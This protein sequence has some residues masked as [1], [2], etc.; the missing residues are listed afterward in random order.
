[1]NAHNEPDIAALTDEVM[2]AGVDVIRAYQ[3]LDEFG[4]SVLAARRAEVRWFELMRAWMDAQG[5][6]Q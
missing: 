1:M 3:A 2:A 4:V 6:E 5:I